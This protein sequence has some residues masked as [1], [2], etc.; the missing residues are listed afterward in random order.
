MYQIQEHPAFLTVLC[1][2][3]SYV[4]VHGRKQFLIYLMVS[5]SFSMILWVVLLL[6]IS[7]G[8]YESA[9]I[10]YLNRINYISVLF[11]RPIFWMR[12]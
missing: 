5:D 7:R 6:S 10:M 2:N 11:L 4:A 12:N 1:R 3:S 8:F 9:L